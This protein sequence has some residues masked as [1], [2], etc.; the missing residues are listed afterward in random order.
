MSAFNTPLMLS[1]RRISIFAL[2]SSAIL[3]ILSSP[4][5]SGDDASIA[6]NGDVNA[7]AGDDSTQGTVDIALASAGSISLNHTNFFT[8]T[9][10]ILGSSGDE[11]KIPGGAVVRVKCFVKNNVS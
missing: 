4:T 7:Q 11:V 2:I 6:L 5:A 1:P 9:I 8:S 10:N 3:T